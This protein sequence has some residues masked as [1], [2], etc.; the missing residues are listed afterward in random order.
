MALDEA[1]AKGAV[2]RQQMDDLKALCARWKQIPIGHWGRPEKEALWDEVWRRI[3]AL[4]DAGLDTPLNGD[5]LPA[6]CDGW[7]DKYWACERRLNRLGHLRWALLAAS[8]RLP[9]IISVIGMIAVLGLIWREV[10]ARHLW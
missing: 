9:V 5:H 1:A 4:V 7:S 10:A 6:G 2:S 8:D 3:D